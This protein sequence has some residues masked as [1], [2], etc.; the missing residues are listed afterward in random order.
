MEKNRARCEVEAALRRSPTTGEVYASDV[1]S[2]VNRPFR[3]KYVFNEPFGSPAARDT[4]ISTPFLILS[5]TLDHVTPLSNAIA[6]GVCFVVSVDWFW[7]SSANVS[8][9]LIP[10]RRGSSLLFQ[11]SVLGSR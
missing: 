8:S 2:Y 10:G 6:W 11:P 9:I 7:F 5:A 4:C 1:R 3:V